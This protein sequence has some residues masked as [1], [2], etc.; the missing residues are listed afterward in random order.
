MN[1]IR[2]TNATEEDINHTGNIVIDSSL[3]GLIMCE[4]NLT[5]QQNGSFQGEAHVENAN[6][7]GSFH[8][9]LEVQERVIF[10]SGARFNGILDAQSMLCSLDSEMIGEIRVIPTKNKR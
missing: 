2:I 5:I 3:K 10:S 9:F 6:I 7:K 8:G 1:T 4:G